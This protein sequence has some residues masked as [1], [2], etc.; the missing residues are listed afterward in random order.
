MT[1]PQWLKQ[2]C[3]STES[4]L[5][6]SWDTLIDP[7]LFH[8]HYEAEQ[9]RSDSAQKKE[10]EKSLSPQAFRFGSQQEREEKN[11]AGAVSG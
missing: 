3:S 11:T 2:L 9:D 6:L 8:I 10:L 5:L 7:Y 1:A 4:P